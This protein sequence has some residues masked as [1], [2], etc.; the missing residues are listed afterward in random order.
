[1][2]Q[3]TSSTYDRY[4]DEEPAPSTAK[5]RKRQSKNSVPLDARGLP[6]KRVV[7]SRKVKDAKGY[8]RKNA[9]DG[10]MIASA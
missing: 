3:K 7:K 10:C 9:V 4:K 8:M 2:N 6:K 1:M 5:K